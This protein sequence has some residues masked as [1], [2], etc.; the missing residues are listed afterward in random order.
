M[1]G[2]GRGQSDEKDRIHKGREGM[3]RTQ[4]RKEKRDILRMEG[5]CSRGRKE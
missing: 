1:G 5:W 2:E 3:E 4:K